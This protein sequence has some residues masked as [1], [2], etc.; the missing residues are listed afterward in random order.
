MYWGLDLVLKYEVITYNSVSKYINFRRFSQFAQ[1]VIF[2][3]LF[4]YITVF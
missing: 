2:R 3:N 4:G 1:D